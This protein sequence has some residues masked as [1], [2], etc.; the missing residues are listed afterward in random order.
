[1]K[2]V[3]FVLKVPRWEQRSTKHLK[4]STP[5]WKASARQRRTCS[6][7]FYHLA[8]PNSFYSDL[9]FLNSHKASSVCWPLQVDCYKG[10]FTGM[11]VISSVPD[12]FFFF[13]RIFTGFFFFLLQC[14]HH[15]W[16]Y[17]LQPDISICLE[18]F[19]CFSSV[20]LSFVCS[21]HVPDCT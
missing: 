16:R 18:P 12:F 15:K 21:D 8:N 6:S 4:T 9:F 10:C 7:Y 20:F 13:Y 14:F 3:L 17:I 19:L 5:F 11:W 1:M 2:S